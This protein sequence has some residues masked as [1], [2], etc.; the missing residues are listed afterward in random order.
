[1]YSIFVSP[2]PMG[3]TKYCKFVVSMSVCL[4]VCSSVRDHVSRS[5]CRF[6][7]MFSCVMYGCGVVILLV[8]R[9]L[10]SFLHML[11]GCSTSPSG[12]GSELSRTQLWFGALE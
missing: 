12:G 7:P 9:F 1:M 5:T 2:P 6:S 11:I 3:S 4:S 8:F 10:V